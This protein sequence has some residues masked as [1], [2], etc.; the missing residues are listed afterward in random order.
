[1][2]EYALNLQTRNDCKIGTCENMYYL[3]YEDRNKVQHIPGN[4]DP[5]T[6]INLRFRL[7]F[8]DEDDTQIGSY[9]KYDRGITLFKTNERGRVE[10]YQDEKGEPGLIQLK[11]PCG[12]LVNATCYHGEKLP[13]GNEDFRPCWNGKGPAYELAFVKNTTDGVL[14]I[15][16]CR[17]CGEM[18]R[19]EWRD[20]ID[21]VPDETLRDRLRK[22]MR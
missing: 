1:M 11:H 19:C 10:W 13:T 20:V 5:S 17:W 15:I 2:G 22:H 14:P 16:R 21:F 9:E 4:I 6:E 18:W 8:P 3:R 12:L 7:P